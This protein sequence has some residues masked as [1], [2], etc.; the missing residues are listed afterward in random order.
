[1]LQII[2]FTDNATNHLKLPTLTELCNDPSLKTQS[3]IKGLL[4]VRDFFFWAKL[5]LKV[6]SFLTYKHLQKAFQLILCLH[7]GLGRIMQ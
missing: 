5:R 2:L 6:K 1:M 7:V 4:V 3:C